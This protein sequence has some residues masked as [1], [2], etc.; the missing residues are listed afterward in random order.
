MI[1]IIKEGNLI[2]FQTVSHDVTG[3][4]VAENELKESEKSLFDIID[5]LPDATFAIN[6]HGKVI[7]WNRA[8]EDITGFKSKDMMGKGNYEYSLP[9]YGIR[10]PILINLVIHP[11]ETFEK[12]YDFIEKQGDGI[13]VETEA[14]LKGI[15]RNLWEKQYHYMITKAISTELSKLFVI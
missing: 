1:P 14:P 8:M 3:K 11:D 4:R 15:N 7:A 9:V 2:G 6:T 13:L 5:F 10:R 12:Q